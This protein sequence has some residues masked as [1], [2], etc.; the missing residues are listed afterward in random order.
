MIIVRND[1][2]YT[3]IEI[4]FV[5][6]ILG[7]V[8]SSLYRVNRNISN[9]WKYNKLQAGLQQE[10]RISM[11]MVVT[12]LQQARFIKSVESSLT[13]KIVYI[14]QKGEKKKI[15]YKSEGGLCLDYDYN[16]ISNRI[17]CFSLKL[18][19]NLLYITLKIEKQNKE[20]LLKTAIKI[21]PEQLN[22]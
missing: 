9:T 2:G 11:N 4:M 22:L 15:Y 3:L 14:D 10:L 20:E 16:I 18:V 8:S 1:S 19:N 6:V 21:R 7:I 17:S 12:N 13:S 5:T